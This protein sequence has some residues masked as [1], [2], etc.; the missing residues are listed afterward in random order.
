MSKDSGDPVKLAVDATALLVPRTGIGTFTAELLKELGRRPDLEVSAFTVGRVGSHWLPDDIRRVVR[1]VPGRLPSR[2]ARRLWRRVPVPRVEWLTGR[3]DVVHGPNYLVPPTRR[4]AT[5]LSVHD[6]GF[7]FDPPMS[8]ASALGHRESVRAGIR[9]GAWLHTVS[10][11]VAQEIRAI[12]D[13]DPDRVVVVPNGACLSEPGPHPAP[14]SPYILAMGAADRRK[15]LTSLVTAFDQVAQE[16]SNLRLIHAGPD[17]DAS[18]ELD[19]AIA[20]SPH[21]QRILRLGW[22]DDH[23][24]ASLFHGA[25][26]VAYPSLYEGFG[27]V[28]LEAMLTDTPVVTTK[29]AAIA[30][31]AGEAALYVTPGDPD[32]LA[33]ALTSALEDTELVARLVASGRERVAEYT[34]ERTAAE[35]TA[36]YRRAVDDL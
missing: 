34:W 5:V 22:V 30:E 14:G 11:Y 8:M 36:L 10:E 19:Q 15:D 9:R 32:E 3:V 25:S 35:M 31:V 26:V 24:R 7:E 4:A 28:P 23:T 20:R 29:V 21:R 17:G 33:E 6:V 13:V 27:L 1:E 18:E 2:I 12:Y 16:F